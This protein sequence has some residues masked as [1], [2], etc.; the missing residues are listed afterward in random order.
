MKQETIDRIRRFSQERDWDQ[1]HTPANLAKSISIEANELLECFQWSDT[2]YDLPHVKEE[3]ADVIDDK[4]PHMTVDSEKRI[5]DEANQ[6][7]KIDKHQ[8]KNSFSFPDNLLLPQPKDAPAEEPQRC[9]NQF[10]AQ[11]RNLNHA[12]YLL[13]RQVATRPLVKARPARF[14]S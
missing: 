12:L 14:P 4:R 9:E 3:V 10:A 2:D 5:K 11:Q 7:G 8:K 6:N 13:K 1:F